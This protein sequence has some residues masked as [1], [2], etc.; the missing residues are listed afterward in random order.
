MKS[1]K[2]SVQDYSKRS[3]GGVLFLKPGYGGSAWRPTWSNA[4]EPRKETHVRFVGPLTED[5]KALMPCRFGPEESEFNQWIVSLPIFTGGTTELFSF[6]P[7]FEDPEHPGE[8]LDGDIYPTPATVFQ[9]HASRMAKQ[10]PALEKLLLLGGKKRRPALP[11][12]MS[13]NA[14]AQCIIM[15]HGTND[16]YKRP[17]CPAII[18]MSDGA[19][20]ALEELLNER[21][22]AYTGDPLDLKARFVA[23]DIL[24]ANE[25]RIVNFYN[26]LSSANPEATAETTVDWQGGDA[27]EKR[28]LVKELPHYTAELKNKMPLPRNRETMQLVGPRGKPLFTPWKDVIRFLDEQEMVD[29]IC[30]AYSDLK[31][32]L[33]DCLRPYSDLLPNFVLGNPTVIV[34]AGKPAA[35]AVASQQ[36][37]AAP[38]TVVQQPLPATDPNTTVVDWDSAEATPAATDTGSDLQDAIAVGLTG[39]EA[40]KQQPVAAVT[41]SN[42]AKVTNAMQKLAALRARHQGQ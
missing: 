23:G 38:Q 32:V 7:L 27:S 9:T 19:R 14:I 36:A 17:Q 6:V 2:Q 5:G 12:R 18:Y 16:Y 4:D 22:P 24:D 34:P 40:G 15:R 31:D 33:R 11:K 42:D 29:V 35:P 21:T 10:D 28:K 39:S 30:R 26:A 1:Y 41:A 37:P 25:G 13:T 3:G 20:L 8:L